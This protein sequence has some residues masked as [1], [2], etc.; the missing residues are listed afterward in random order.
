MPFLVEGLCCCGLKYSFSSFETM[1]RFIGI[2]MIAVAAGVLLLLVGEFC[3]VSIFHRV[4]I[5][6]QPLI[7]P[8]RVTCAAGN[9]MLLEDGREIEV[10]LRWGG[11]SLLDVLRESG[12]QVTI[13]T[14]EDTT[15][16]FARERIH[17]CMA[18]RAKTVLPLIPI[19]YLVY[20]QR[21]LGEETRVE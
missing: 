19:R 2:C 4:P 8:V 3:G 7:E 15:F 21:L 11:A 17:Y 12:C 13:V 10:E 5:Y 1:H 6:N 18:G 20:E 14:T 9:R 16:V